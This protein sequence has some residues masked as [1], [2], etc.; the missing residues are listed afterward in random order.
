MLLTAWSFRT[1]FIDWKTS[2]CCY[3]LSFV[4]DFFDGYAARYFKQCK[5]Q[6]YITLLNTYSCI[7]YIGSDF[8]AVLDMITDRCSTAGLLFILSHLY[9]DYLFAFLA[10]LMLEF[11]SH[12]V[13]MYSSKGS[14]KDVSRDRNVILQLYYGVY[15]FFGYCCV[16]TELTYILLYVLSFNP[17]MTLLSTAIRIDQVCTIIWP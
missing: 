2:I 15:P 1:A 9:P 10:L 12:W 3:F 11:S 5:F 8:G 14:H 6:I 4:C 17:D 13:H 16:G 7:H